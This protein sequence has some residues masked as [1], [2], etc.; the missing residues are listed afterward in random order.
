MGWSDAFAELG[1]VIAS[2]AELIAVGATPRMLTAAV[3]HRSLLRVRRDHYAVP[4]TDKHVLRAVRVGGRITC[5]TAARHVGLF[6][7]DSRRTHIQLDHGASRLRA[8]DAPRRPLISRTD[9]AVLHWHQLA[10]A[11]SGSEYSVDLLDALECIAR[12]AESRFAIASLDSALHQGSV[13][14]VDVAELFTR[15]PE[16]LQWLRGRLNGRSESGQESV[17]RLGLEDAGLEPQIQVDIPG[18]GRVD[19]VVEGRLICEADSRGFHDGW[20]SHVRDRDRDLAAARLGYMTLRP[21]YHR[22]MF[23]TSSVIESVTGLLV[24]TSGTRRRS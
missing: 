20:E 19:A 21:T 15:L 13:S 18:V 4:G 2:R 17:L 5:H 9:D 12:C 3:R 10:D 11:R 1:R 7:F 24:A 8:P 14:E 23:E 22:I 6:G 16:R